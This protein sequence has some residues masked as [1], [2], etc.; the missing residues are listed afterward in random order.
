MS[1]A[2]AAPR[3][4]DAAQQ[5][6]SALRRILRPLVRVMLRNG[7]AAGAFVE[8][9][10]Q[11]FAEVAYEE[12]ALPGKRPSVARASTITG[13][14]RKEVS[15]LLS[16]TKPDDKP[17]FY[18]RAARVVTGWVSDKHFCDSDGNPL[19]LR[20]DEGE[21][22]FAKLVRAKSG[23]MTARAVLDELERVG[24]VEVRAD[25]F[26]ELQHR[27]YV[28]ESDAAEKLGILG[29]DVAD[30][31]ATIDHNLV[32]PADEAFF[33]RK[34]SYDRLVPSALPRL[35]AMIRERGQALLEEL[36]DY[37]APLDRDLDPTLGEGRAQ[38]KAMIGIY[39]YEEDTTALAAQGSGGRE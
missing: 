28:P 24:A 10:K 32:C 39:Y 11:V 37:M 12:F 7:V 3:T 5:S 18:N 4:A 26:I 35:K 8:T 25:G 36:N 1:G 20:F 17:S 33:Q 30:L 9:A 27:A 21:P 23:D 13:M 22:S 31:V 6:L 16:V 34:V 19:R 15:R 29:T 14:N 38:R 2:A